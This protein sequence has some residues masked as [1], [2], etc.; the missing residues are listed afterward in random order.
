MG[1]QLRK[2]LIAFPYKIINQKMEMLGLRLKIT[3]IHQVRFQ[4]LYFKKMK[5]TAEKYLGSE[6]KVKL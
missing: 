4:H 6:V 3:N 1:Q 5:E 2:I